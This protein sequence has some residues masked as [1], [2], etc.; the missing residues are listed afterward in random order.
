M[1]WEVAWDIMKKIIYLPTF[2]FLKRD[3]IRYGCD[4]LEKKGFEIE[5]WRVIDE[6]SYFYEYDSQKLLE[7]DNYKQLNIQEF[8]KL[9]DAENDC[10]FV[11]LSTG[12][13]L[14]SL[15]AE[16][17]KKFI[18][19]AG[20]GA[21]PEINMDKT[22]QSRVDIVQDKIEHLKRN[23]LGKIIQ[24]RLNYRKSINKRKEFISR[25][26]MAIEQN[27][28]AAIFTSTKYA[29]E[30]YLSE[31]EQSENVI[32][33]HSYDY[34]RYL[35]AIR[36]DSIMDPCIVYCD[37]GYSTQN[38][39]ASRWGWVD[40][41]YIH[42]EEYYSQLECLFIKLENHYGV[43]VVIA[44]HPHTVY[45]PDDFGSREI[46]Y[47]QIHRLSKNAKGF[48]LNIS[49]A[50]SYGLL[51]DLPILAI[52]ND[53]FKDPPRAIYEEIRYRA[54]DMLDVGFINMSNNEEMEEPWNNMKA[55]DRNLRREYIRKYIIDSDYTDKTTYEILGDF[56]KNL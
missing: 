9:L 46:V 45:K 8:T 10:I 25:Y 5:V 55:A 21:S 26:N 12:D 4:Y 28:P 19:I 38:Q 35:E 13:S 43:P 34:D 16:S 41:N 42:R 56:L 54:Q 51:Y 20:M 50:I 37:S 17:G 15:V 18:V 1:A 48:I 22:S 27:H 2:N 40:S 29:S 53:Y 24:N 32:Y 36:D 33:T 31:K 14:S 30:I 23:G 11:L 3:Y 6:N 44:G 49:V 7:R 47:D 39:E 52:A